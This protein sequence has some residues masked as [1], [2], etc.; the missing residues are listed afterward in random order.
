M[1]MNYVRIDD[2]KEAL[3]EYFSG[4]KDKVEIVV[5]ITAQAVVDEKN[6][7]YVPADPYKKYNNKKYKQGTSFHN[8]IDLLKDVGEE[9]VVNFICSRFPQSRINM[10]KKH[11]S[12]GKSLSLVDVDDARISNEIE[13]ELRRVVGEKRYRLAKTR[14]IALY[15]Y[16]PDES[17]GQLKMAAKDLVVTDIQIVLLSEKINNYLEKESDP[18]KGL[19]DRL[20]DLRSGRDRLM[21]LLG[22]TAGDIE[23]KR[24]NSKTGFMKSAESLAL[25]IDDAIATADLIKDSKIILGEKQAEIVE[26]EEIF[27]DEE[28]LDEI[29][30]ALVKEPAGETDDVTL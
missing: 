14:I 1:A 11:V 28:E 18:P 15:D 23:K 12:L 7:M 24:D 10:G 3:A 9:G 30:I 25:R 5:R 27:G 13:K 26:E 2:Y 22:L 29:D 8:F 16:L 19:F 6:G 17:S 20:K 4:D 21:N